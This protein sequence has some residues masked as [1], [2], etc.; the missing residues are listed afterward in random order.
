ML[1]NDQSFDERSRASSELSSK[2]PESLIKKGDFTLMDSSDWEARYKNYNALMEV[3]PLYYD[4][5]MNAWVASRYED[6]STLSRDNR[7]D[8]NRIIPDKVASLPEDVAIAL[9]PITDFVSTWM[10]YNQDPVHI[11]L[12][13]PMGRTFAKHNMES[14]L[15]MIE[16]ITREVCHQ[17]KREHQTGE[18]DFI[19]DFAHPIPAIILG[20]MLGVP[21]E[22]IP[23]FLGW[24]DQLAAFMQNFVVSSIPD[25]R[26]AAATTS[27]IEEIKIYFE[28]AVR[29]R[30]K[31]GSQDVLGDVVNHTNLAV[32]TIRNQCI[33]LMFGGHKVPEFLAGTMMYN[34]GI[35]PSLLNEVK[36]NRDLINSTANEAIRYDSPIQFITR[37]ANEPLKIRGTDIKEGDAVLLL[38][39]SANRDKRVFENPESFDIHRPHNKHLG[40]GAGSHVCLGMPLVTIEIKGMFNALFDEFPNIRLANPDSVP[41]WSDN[42]TFHGLRHLKVRFD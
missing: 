4:Q 42:P 34:L 20:S 5:M 13:R 17:I 8:L 9:K 24:S 26:L 12:K 33:H 7:L 1:S 14:V 16:E 32:E 21:K 10:I 31:A 40:F 6:V 28:K 19:K 18:F 30:Q 37:A 2:H 15:P 29:S 35:R 11:D 27:T 3:A 41:A 38:L 23:R 22:E 25:Q 36:G 39:G